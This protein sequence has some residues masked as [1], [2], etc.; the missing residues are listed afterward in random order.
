MRTCIKKVQDQAL[1]TPAIEV[2]DNF[3]RLFKP[4]NP[5][6]YYKNLHIEYYYFCQQ[7]KDY[8]E[9]AGLLDHKY[10]FFAAKFLK[11]HIFNC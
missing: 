8:F 9:V 10:V 4:W 1:A 7:Y 11:D 3:N 6:L 5:H 2:R